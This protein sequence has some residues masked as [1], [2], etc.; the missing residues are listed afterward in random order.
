MKKIAITII[1][2]V[3]TSIIWAQGNL[4]D[5]VYLKNGSII[6]GTIVEQKIGESLT[7]ETMDGSRFVYA[8]DQVSRITREQPKETKPEAKK[9]D[10]ESASRIKYSYYSLN[11]GTV[12]LF[13]PALMVGIGYS[14]A[15]LNFASQN[16]WGGTLQW[17]GD[18]IR[19]TSFRLSMGHLVAGPSYTFVQE[20]LHAAY[21]I[22]IPIGL[23][24][25]AGVGYSDYS[26]KIVSGWDFAFRMGLGCSIRTNISKRASF[27]S[28][29]DLFIIPSGGTVAIG[30]NASFGFS[31]NW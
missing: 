6:R 1:M 14:I 31:I 4:V 26:G 3:L 10:V 18:Y 8:I 16:G 11:I 28:K 19:N 7:I 12:I 29:I 17:G 25:M 21:T 2:L 15:D 27:Y 23:V 24:G 9:N 22:Y 20:R 13:E 5:V 30:T